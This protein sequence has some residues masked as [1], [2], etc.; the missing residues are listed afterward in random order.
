LGLAFLVAHGT[1]RLGRARWIVPV[2]VATDALIVA[3][4]AGM[5]TSRPVWDDGSCAVL[6]T[7]EPG[8]IVDL[9]PTFHELYL[10]AQRCHGLPVAEGINR[11]LGSRTQ[12]LLRATRSPV[13]GASVLGDAGYRYLVWH[14]AVAGDQYRDVADAVS[15]CE[16]AR[17]GETIVYALPCDP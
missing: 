13:E 3:G 12:E 17:G 4:G 2:V 8:P 9:P 10:G 1:R 15:A 11:P 6:T 5:L 7:L 14:G 16:V